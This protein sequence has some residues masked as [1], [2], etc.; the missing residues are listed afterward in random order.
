MTA[1]RLATLARIGELENQLAA[2]H[3]LNADLRFQRDRARSTVGT[4]Q[5]RI[6]ELE[7]R[8][9]VRLDPKGRQR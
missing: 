8:L 9:A 5:T 2:A 1:E 4:Q 3:R 7:G 6:R